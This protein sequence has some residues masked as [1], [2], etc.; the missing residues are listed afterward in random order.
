[1]DAFDNVLRQRAHSEPFFLPEDFA[2]RVFATC[3]SLE[4][5]TVVLPGAA[6][7]RTLRRWM[8]GVAAALAIFVAVPNLSAPAAQAMERIPVL[9][10]VVRV[11][12][13]R[14]YTQD[15]DHTHA[16]VSVPA[17]EGAGSAGSAVN[18][19]VQAYIDQ[20]MEQFKADCAAIGEGYAGLDVSYAVTADTD[21][22]F[23]LRVD[24]LETQASGYE[25]SRIYNLD[26]ATGQVVTLGGLFRE[27]TPWQKALSDE[28]LRQMNEQMK[29]DPDNKTY[30]TDEFTGVTAD[31]NYYFGKDGALVLAFDEYAVDPG[32]M[33]PVEFTIPKSVW[34]SYRR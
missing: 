21:D 9:G 20:L 12:T 33:G 17:L 1:M 31:Q 5:K 19:E 3:A 15:T 6:P 11:I 16:D 28:V 18:A 7:H 14:H 23:T 29:Q 8:I 13:F 27:G 24:A 30:F 2:G 22:W 34:A 25:F 4:E 32:F 26:K 10:A